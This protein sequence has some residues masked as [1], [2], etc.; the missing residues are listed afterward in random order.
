M[1][2]INPD[3]DIPYYI[4]DEIIEYIELSKVTCKCMKFENLKYLL[5]LA[6]VNKHLTVRQA[7]ILLD[8]CNRES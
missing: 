6:I 2:Q 8:R 5:N 1:E 7:Q 4:F 3:F